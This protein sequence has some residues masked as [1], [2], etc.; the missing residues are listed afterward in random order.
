MLKIIE[1]IFDNPIGTLIN[2]STM[3]VISFVWKKRYIK[4]ANNPY[5]AKKEIS[6]HHPDNFQQKV[7]TKINEQYSF[8]ERKHG[9]N[10]TREIA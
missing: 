9:I 1:I 6:K 7:L 3:K 5:K 4:K 8:F 2:Y 10:I